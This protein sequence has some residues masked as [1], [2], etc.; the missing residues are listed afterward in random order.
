MLLSIN[1]PGSRYYLKIINVP[2]AF[3][4]YNLLITLEKQ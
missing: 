1:K 4:T 3:G 2:F